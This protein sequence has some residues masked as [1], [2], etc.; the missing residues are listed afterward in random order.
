M[1]AV[2]RG[3]GMRQGM[4]SGCDRIWTGIITGING[5]ATEDGEWPTYTVGYGQRL[6]PVLA[7]EVDGCSVRK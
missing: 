5:D 1:D 4:G 6:C 2:V 3:L 7:G